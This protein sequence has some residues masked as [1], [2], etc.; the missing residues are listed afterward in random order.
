MVKYSG[1]GV[2][3][4]VQWRECYGNVLLALRSVILCRVWVWGGTKRFLVI[5]ILESFDDKVMGFTFPEHILLPY[6]SLYTIPLPFPVP[7]TFFRELKTWK[8]W[9]K[10]SQK[11]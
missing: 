11:I 7:C 10:N 4:M 6:F 8:K 9:R 2:G 1:V 5:V 3:W